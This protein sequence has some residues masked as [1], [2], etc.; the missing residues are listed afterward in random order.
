[1]KLGRIIDLSHTIIPGEEEYRLELDTRLVD[2]WEQF[3]KYPR[4]CDSWYV[5]SEVMMS[6]HTGTHVEFPFHHVKDGLDAATFPLENL[7]GLGVV[8][9]VSNWG[10][11]QE[12]SLEGLKRVAESKIQPGDIVYFYT[13][14]DIYYHTEKQHRRPWFSTEAVEWLVEEAGI[15]VMGVDAS[16]IEPRKPDGSPYEGQPN[17][18]S[19]LEAGIPIVEYMTNLESLIDNRFLTFILP[20]KIAGA[21]A[22]PVRIIAVMPEGK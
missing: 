9:D 4:I 7:V 22:L 2:E 3:A 21:E 10:N 20:V 15:K 13:G 6:I 5:I 19:L 11:G 8:I 17:H 12:I 14:C 1:M 16:G 18:E